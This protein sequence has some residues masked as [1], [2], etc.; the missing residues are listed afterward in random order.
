MNI[1]VR[2]AAKFGM[3]FSNLRVEGASSAATVLGATTYVGYSERASLFYKIKALYSFWLRRICE[4]ERCS[5][6]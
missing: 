4:E 3:D 5:I 6:W 2:L 1:S